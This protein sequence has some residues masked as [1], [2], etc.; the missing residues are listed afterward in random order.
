MFWTEWSN[1]NSNGTFL[2]E[3][4]RGIRIWMKENFWVK[5]LITYLIPF[6]NFNSGH[7]LDS[8]MSSITDSN[9]RVNSSKA[10]T[11]KNLSNT[12]CSLKSMSH[13]YIVASC[14]SCLCLRYN[15][16]VGRELFAVWWR[17]AP[18]KTTTLTFGAV[19]TGAPTAIG[20]RLFF[21]WT[22]NVLHNFTWSTNVK[23]RSRGHP[24]IKVHW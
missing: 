10:A 20:A 22:F 3:S 16:G 24:H 18:L 9:A 15:S 7:M 2:P 5:T 8:Y 11:S 4:C 13:V 12:I 23:I 6:R 17:M 19:I 21:W 14:M 1:F